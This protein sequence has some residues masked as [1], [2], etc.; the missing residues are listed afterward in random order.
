MRLTTRPQ[1]VQV[2]STPRRRPSAKVLVTDRYPSGEV[3]PAWRPSFQAPTDDSE[4]DMNP[5]W[6]EA[7]K[8]TRAPTAAE[9]EITNAA[10]IKR[11]QQQP[12][13]E[14]ATDSGPEEGIDVF[15][16]HE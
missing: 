10:N 14:V 6:N 1:A 13:F 15:W 5:I 3:K 9:K 8:T 16:E 11:Y 7:S 4:V 2:I 12:K